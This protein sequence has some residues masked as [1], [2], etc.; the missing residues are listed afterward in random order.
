MSTTMHGVD[1]VTP[2]NGGYRRL[3]EVSFLSD[4]LVPGVKFFF[5]SHSE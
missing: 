1:A 4:S 5:G 2:F 3:K